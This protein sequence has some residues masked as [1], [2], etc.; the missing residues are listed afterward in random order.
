MDYIPVKFQ[1]WVR[2]E[3]GADPH[4]MLQSHKN[5]SGNRVKQF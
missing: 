1:G 5:L 3:S 4:Q 2:K